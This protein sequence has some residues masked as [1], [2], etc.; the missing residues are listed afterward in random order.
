MFFQTWKMPRFLPKSILKSG[1]GKS[2]WSTSF[3][4]S[5]LLI[6]HLGDANGTEYLLAS[7]QLVKSFNA[8]FLKNV[9][10]LDDACTI[11]DDILGTL[12][13]R[14]NGDANAN[15]KG[16]ILPEVLNLHIHDV[17]TPRR[18]RDNAWFGVV[19]KT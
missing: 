9:E 1:T 16:S 2:N 6:R 7:R 14:E 15:R 13:L 18:G 11:A 5:P 19:A 4:S 8:A 10:G 17:V 12:R 3:P